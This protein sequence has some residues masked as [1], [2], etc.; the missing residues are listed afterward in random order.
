MA[1]KTVIEKSDSPSPEVTVFKISG[2]LGFHE[3]ATLEKLFDECGK[4]DMHRVVLDMEGLA[5][6][7]G[8]CAQILRDRATTGGFVIGISGARKTAL[9]FL[10]KDPVET[11]L[12]ADDIKSA[13]ENVRKVELSAAGVAPAGADPGEKPAKAAPKPAARPAKTKKSASPA[14]ADPSLSKAGVNELKKR[15]VQYNAI[16]TINSDFYAIN[17]RKSLLELLLLTMIAQIGVESAMFLEH[18]QGYFVPAAAKG[19]EADEMRGLAISGEELGLDEWGETRSV[20]SIDEVPFS[21][22]VKAPL[23]SLGCSFV[24]PF[25]VHGAFYG[26]ILLGKSIKDNMDEGAIDLLK[27]LINQAALAYGSMAKFEA[28]NE[29]TLGLVH[30]LMSLIEENTLGRGNTNL[31][32]NY[33]HVLSQ[34]IHYPE[35][36]TRDLMYGT[37]LRDI[38]MIK[39]S[40]L[41]VRSPR[42]LVP[43][44]WEI[45]KR[46]PIDGADMLRNMKF[47]E[48]SVNIV[49]AHHERFNGEGYPNGIQGQDIPLGA[50]IV[51]VVESYAAMLQERPT[52]PALSQ[53]EAL[54]TLRENW[55]MRYDPDLVRHFVEFVE[56]EIKSGENLADQRFELLKV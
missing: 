45:I 24:A 5:S 14:A 11:I 35:E 16:F 48:H 27:I 9:L 39:V 20:Y 33:V 34:R 54:N 42:E 7:G 21:D 8:G 15:I 4:R 17:D 50:R 36:T 29:R 40:D 12:V 49:L 47:S 32:S 38:G 22:D 46:H 43:E 53:E 1:P 55:G 28:E 30:T 31:I 6:L 18:S 2:T 10:T 25:I 3:K 13:V 26:I 41:I 23:L 51:S 56:G 52:R 44:E 37:V 19:I